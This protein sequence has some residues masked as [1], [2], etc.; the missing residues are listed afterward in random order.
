MAFQIDQIQI[1]GKNPTYNLKSRS[2]SGTGPRSAYLQSGPVPIT[3]YWVLGPV[4]ELNNWELGPDFIYFLLWK[5]LVPIDNLS[6]L[7]PV[8]EI[9]NWQLGL[10]PELHNWQLGPN[11][12]F[13]VGCSIPPPTPTL[14]FALYSHFERRYENKS[15]Q[16]WSNMI[17]GIIGK[18]QVKVKSLVLVSVQV[19]LRTSP[20]GWLHH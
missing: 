10:V 16:L 8:P 17:F 15:F 4:P 11:F 20:G 6:S 7:G 5:Y 3:N 9:H 12:F 1:T 13:H 14:L 2:T 19:G 18:V